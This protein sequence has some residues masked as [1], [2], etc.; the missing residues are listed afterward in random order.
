MN[1]RTFAFG[2]PANARSLARA[3]CVSASRA[4]T[5]SSASEYRTCKLLRA[6]DIKCVPALAAVRSHVLRFDSK[7]RARAPLSL[8]LSLSRARARV[9]HF[10]LYAAP[11]A[12]CSLS[13]IRGL[14]RLQPQYPA[15]GSA[16]A[17]AF[18]SRFRAI[19]FNRRPSAGIASCPRKVSPFEIISFS[20]VFHWCAGPFA[21]MD[22]RAGGNR[23]KNRDSPDIKTRESFKFAREFGKGFKRIAFSSPPPELAIFPESVIFT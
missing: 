14:S 9:E 5:I 17:L 8:S 18:P 4:R 10:V 12:G 7:F 21:R 2:E 1:E 20:G 19:Y 15:K 13:T 6:F 23:Y 11:I 16:F 22:S 3:S